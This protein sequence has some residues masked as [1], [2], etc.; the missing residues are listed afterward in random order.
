MKIGRNAP[1][2]CGSGKKYKK[3]CLRRSVTPQ[4][5]LHYRRLSKALDKLMKGAVS[6]AEAAFGDMVFSYAMDEFF[7]WPDPGE[8]PDME[9]VERAAPLF[10]PWMV[11]NW[12]YD[13]LEDEGGLLEGPE[14]AT[15]AE[16]YA[17]KKRIAPQSDEGR[18][19]AAANRKPYSFM[20]V[21][22]LR[23]GESVRVRDLLTGAEA[24]AQERLGSEALQAGDILFGRIARVQDV[25]MFLGMSAFAMPPRMKPDI[26]ALRRRI[27]GPSGKVTADEL[28]EWDLEI[29][30][31]FWDADRLLHSPPEIR[32]TDGDPIEFHKLIYDIDSPGLAVEKLA[33]LCADATVEEI[34]AEA[35]KDRHGNVRRATLRWTREGDAVSPGMSGTLLGTIEIE[36]GRMTV[37]V[38]SLQRAEA[39]R[40]QIEKRLGPAAR[41]RLDEIADAGKMA[42]E[43]DSPASPDPSLADAPEV[44]ERISQ[45]LRAH[46][47]GWVNQE[48][49]ALG[50][51]T[52]R[53]A[54]RS[55]DGREAVEAL[56]QDAERTAAGDP[57]R[58]SVENELIADV[59]RRLKLDRPLR[60]GRDGLDPTGLAERICRIKGRIEKFG[61]QRLHDTYTDFALEL[62][63]AVAECDMLNIHRGRI[64]I[65]AAAVVYAV[66]RLN[67][68]F[69]SETL[70]HL[71]ADEL[72]GW[73]GQKKSTVGAKASAILDALDL[74]HA[75]ERFCAPHIT[76]LFRIYENED[77]LL[78]PASA[79]E[80]E[81]NGWHEPLP[82]K[83]PAGDKKEE[84]LKA[85]KPE[86]KPGEKNDR[87]MS[88]FRD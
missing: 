11:F 75:D 59:R 41:F 71:T 25:G 55:A 74:H 85:E 65:W 49:P 9:A 32:N 17:A 47:E 80:S 81:G 31:V 73:F 26:I 30:E 37:L 43:L 51:R 33:P 39:I 5:T 46:W 67:F 13:S 56:L 82:L 36:G 24:T 61:S 20:E 23:P 53:Q 21:T 84:G 77:G 29:R 1:C 63:D 57:A 68:L 12:E 48:I 52:P 69:S 18:L 28:Y 7:G 4:A 14:D 34:R 22:G 27:S 45:M 88:L 87:Q 72:C 44:R 50:H 83:P 8:E 79:V 2:P 42:A 70:H 58:A 66:A 54:V 16:M 15:V 10:W 62:C 40:E 6:H 19:I 3:C 60:S 64:G 78:I 35:E 38:N 86:E 76:Q